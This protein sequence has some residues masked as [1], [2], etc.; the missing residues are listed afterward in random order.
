M[1]ISLYY[2]KQVR[3]IAQFLGSFVAG[4][5]GGFRSELGSSVAIR[6]QSHQ[7]WICRIEGGWGGGGGGRDGDVW[8]TQEHG[9]WG[10]WGGEEGGC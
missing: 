4:L 3:G 10:E 1:G 6:S 8:E 2:K 9:R 5:F 7:E